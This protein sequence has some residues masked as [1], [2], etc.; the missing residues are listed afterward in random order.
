MNGE[1]KTQGKFEI[2][3]TPEGKEVLNLDN[4]A[5]YELN[6]DKGSIQ[7]TAPDPD[8]HSSKATGKFYF[9]EY[10]D[11]SRIFLEDGNLFQ[12]II[13]PERLP[14][15]R[16]EPKKKATWSNRILTENHLMQILK[17]K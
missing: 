16:D 15:K 8:K 13:F 2:F 6:R 5:Y 7:S 4:Q 3:T 12:E 17:T 11:E 1:L 14:T 10:T 9:A